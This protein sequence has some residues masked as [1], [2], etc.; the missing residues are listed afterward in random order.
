MRYFLLGCA[1]VLSVVLGGCL[2][3]HDCF[4]IQVKPEGQAF[5]RKLTCWH[6]GGPD[7]KSI[8]PLGPAEVARIGNLYPKPAVPTD[9]KKHIFTGRFHGGTPPISV[10]RGRTRTSPP[11]WAAPRAT[12]SGFA[13]MTTW[14]RNYPN[15][16]RKRIGWPIS[17]WA[18]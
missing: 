13:G 2:S 10:G 15:G 18:G 17:W 11:P 5:Q 6:V 8:R 7:N 4:E 14:H 3:E 12:S 16:A 1:A 9:A